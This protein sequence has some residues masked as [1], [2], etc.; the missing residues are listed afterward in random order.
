MGAVS[1]SHQSLEKVQLFPQVYLFELLEG[2]INILKCMNK[3]R[4]MCLVHNNNVF[5][6]MYLQKLYF[7]IVFI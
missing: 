1:I 2:K 7:Y 6:Y 3:Q 4:Y 5:D